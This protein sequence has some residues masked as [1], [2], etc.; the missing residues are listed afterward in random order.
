MNKKSSILIKARF[1]GMHCWKDAFEEV[2]F[3]RQLHRHEFHVNIEM[4]VQATDRELEFIKVKRDLQKEL[5]CKMPKTSNDSCEQMA[6]DIANYLFNRYGERSLRV[7]VL[8]DGENGGT[9]SYEL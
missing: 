4:G 3:L 1:D 7:E 2:A 9:V 8:E 6:I 5:L